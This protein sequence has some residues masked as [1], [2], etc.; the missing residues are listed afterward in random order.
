M[1]KEMRL[2]AVLIV[3]I[4][5]AFFCIMPIASAVEVIQVQEPNQPQVANPFASIGA[6]FSS[7]FFWWLLGILIIVIILGVVGYFLVKWAIKYIKLQNDMFYQIRKERIKL[8]S[9]QKRLSSSWTWWKCWQYKQN[10]PIRLIRKDK[11]GKPQISSPVAYYRG[12]FQGHEGNLF[13]SFNM[14]GNHYLWGLIPKT[15]LLIIP[16]RKEMTI[17]IHKGRGETEDRKFENLPTVNDIVQFNPNEILLYA[18]GI[19]NTNYFYF[20][21]LKTPNGKI[22]DLSM[23]IYA[24]MQELA[25]TEMMYS[26]TDMYAKSSKKIVELN[27]SVRYVS[28]TGDM[29]QSVEVPVKAD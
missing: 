8:A 28:K 23:P 29:N 11:D 9:A 3:L 4:L 19:S 2:G 6:F 10:P 13:I 16:D 24:G 15:E 21:V 27:P 20:P 14:K 1:K 22:I 26:Q 17:K 25:V 5:F 18:D 12:D 7:S